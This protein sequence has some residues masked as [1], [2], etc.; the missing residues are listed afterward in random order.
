MSAPAPMVG[1]SQLD[2]ERFGVRT[3][4]AKLNSAEDLADLMEFCRGQR[5]TLAIARAPVGQVRLAQALE[6]R[7]F[8]LMDVLGYYLCGLRPPPRLEGSSDMQVRPVRTGE[9][10]AVRELARR[11]FHDY[12]DHYHADP[13]LPPDQCDEVY[14]SWAF[15]ACTLKEVAD[16]VL[17]AESEGRPAGFGAIKR[18]PG[19]Q[20][21]GV[22][23]G[24]APEARGRGTF[25]ALMVHSLREAAQAG[26]EEMVYSTQL[27]NLAAQKVLVR[28]GF[29]LRQAVWTFHKWFD[30]GGG[31]G[32]GEAL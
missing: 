8:R 32:D 23:Y 27:A 25:R 30:P 2:E 20:M 3:A 13:R 1:L 15:R 22:L 7:G 16:I 19:K 18:L 12:L 21:D 17:V 29:E 6:D 4:K 31:P 9:E 26:A 10:D 5:V 28:L 24:V 14:A 11:A